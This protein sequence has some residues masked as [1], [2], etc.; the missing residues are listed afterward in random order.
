MRDPQD[1][2]MPICPV[3]WQE[4]ETIYRFRDTG[5]VI[6]CDECIEAV[7]AWEYTRTE[8]DDES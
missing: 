4:C 1:K 8:G 6:G 5:D 3:C 7:D 2:A